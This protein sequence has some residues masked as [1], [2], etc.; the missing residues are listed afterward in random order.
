MPTMGDAQRV[1]QGG[2]SKLADGQRTNSDLSKVGSGLTRGPNQGKKL[3]AA[4]WSETWPAPGSTLDLDFAN[5]RGWVRGVGQGKSMD[6]VTFTRASNAN[7][8]DSAGLI[9]NAINGQPRF[10]WAS[11]EQVVG[12]LLKQ[13][14]DFS[15]SPWFYLQASGSISLDANAPGVMYAI[16]S[17]IDSINSSTRYLAQTLGITANTKYRLTFY[18][19]AGNVGLLFLIRNDDADRRAVFD[20]SSGS[21]FST[22][23]TTASI[24]F[25]AGS[26]YRCAVTWTSGND[27]SILPSFNPATPAFG[28][29][30]TMF[31]ISAPDLRVVVGDEDI[32]PYAATGT[33]TPIS[34]ALAANPTSNGLLIEESRANRILWCRDAT[35][36]AWTKTNVTAAKD[37]TGIDGVANAASSLT[38]TA[39]DGT[40]IQT[41]TLAS[42][43]RTGSVYLKRITGT[44]NVQV[45]LDGST[46]STVDLSAS[47]WRRIV[48]SGTVTNPAVGIKLAVSGDAVAMDY[49]QVEDGAFVTS[50]IL[51]TTASVTRAADFVSML[52]PNINGFYNLGEGTIAVNFYTF[53]SGTNKTLAQFNFATG[54]SL[55][56]VQLN[57][58]TSNRLRCQIR[59]NAGTPANS[60]LSPA[61]IVEANK[62]NY[63]AGSY[64]LA[65][66]SAVNNGSFATESA[67]N[68]GSTPEIRFL[69]IGSISQAGGESVNGYIKRITYLPKKSQGSFLQSLTGLPA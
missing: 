47:E 12:N 48:L 23:N 56:Y 44:G 25:I 51:T 11:T 27:V 14:N 31:Y 40:C 52:E 21:V 32:P 3:N 41:I 61:I 50:P 42:G 13:T 57:I 38:A 53:V 2:L 59:I 10:D 54:T 69:F 16:N 33:I 45:S 1:G 24:E 4:A 17:G 18:A 6:A 37:Q 34:I 63:I 68:L 19:K 66:F 8:V 62:F 36:A 15:V 58:D 65:N 46:Y 28:D 30:S 26:V 9:T 43:S 22:N 39:N 64:S 60:G 55:N 20:L 29:G 7:Y 5:D 35:D 49:G 67:N